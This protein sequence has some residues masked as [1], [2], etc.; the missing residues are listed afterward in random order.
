MTDLD[1][2]TTNAAA[3]LVGVRPATIRKWK[4]RGY[5][6][7]I[8]NTEPLMFHV[9][10]VTEAAV[11]RRTQ[12]RRDALDRAREHFQQATTDQP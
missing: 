3:E 11:A 8:N 9:D 10:D 5:L 4:Q 1:I 7:P 6:Q 12:A 2:L